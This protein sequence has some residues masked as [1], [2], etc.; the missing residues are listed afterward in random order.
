M[1]KKTKWI[2]ICLIFVILSGCA[3]LRPGYET[4][5]VSI[6]SFEPIPTKGI[7]PHFKIGLH[8]VNPNGSPLDFKGISYTIALEGHKIMT[9]VS[10]QLPQ[11]MAY[12]EGDIVLNASIDLFSS[13]RFF[14]DIIRSKNTDKISYSLTAKIDTGPLHPVIRVRKKGE[15]SLEKPIQKAPNE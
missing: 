12:G 6:T 2:F 1:T 8:I 5:V 10:N 11:I 13:I 14:S 15:L 7:M 3:A 9:G 4:P